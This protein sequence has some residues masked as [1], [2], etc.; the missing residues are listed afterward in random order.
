MSNTID[1]RIVQMK[2]NNSQFEQG[3]S[4][5]MNT[6]DKLKKSLDF[7]DTEKALNNLNK[8]TSENTLGELGNSASIVEAKLSALNV[9]A[10]TVVSN[11]TTSVINA[12][13]KISSSLYDLGV[14]GGLNRALNIEQAKFQLEGLGITW[15]SIS[16][17][18]SYAVNETAYSL[19][20]AAK[21]ASTL[22]ATGIQVGNIAR[23]IET[24]DS[25]G[26][27]TTSTIDSMAESLR[28]ISG[29]ASQTGASY[30]NVSQ[31]FSTIAGNGRIMGMQ[32]TQLASYG[33]NVAADMANAFG[34]TE[35]E[36]RDQVSEGLIS[37]E[38]F[39][40]VMFDKYADHAVKANETLSG[41]ASNIRS[42]FAKI[43]AE[44][45]QPIV[46]NNGPLV[47][48]LNNFKS[49][50]DE[51]KVAMIPMMEWLSDDAIKVINKI[52]TGLKNLDFSKLNLEKGTAAFTNFHKAAAA[53]Q[54]I[55][56]ALA[57]WIK[58]AWNGIVSVFQ[59]G[60]LQ[61]IFDNLTSTITNFFSKLTLGEKGA[62]N[63]QRI[64]RGLTSVFD[65]FLKLLNSIGIGFLKFEGITVEAGSGLLDILA[66][67]GDWLYQL[68][69][70]IPDVSS[71]FTTL[72]NVLSDITSKAN[73][74]E[75]ILS[76]VAGTIKLI[77]QAFQAVIPVLSKAFSF[78]GGIIHQLWDAIT[79]S[80]DLTKII[81]MGLFGVILYQLKKIGI[82]INKI[83][84]AITAKGSFLGLKDLA[85][86]VSLLLDQVHDS[87]FAWEESLKANFFLKIASAI[88]ILAVA[89]TVISNIDVDKLVKAL[90]A[91]SLLMNKLMTNFATFSNLSLGKGVW[92]L[93]AV[94]IGFTASIL[95][96]A[97]AVKKLSSIDLVGLAKGIAG[98]LILI[99]S[100]TNALDS[101]VISK[102]TKI[103]KCS[104]LLLSLA[105]SIRVLVSSV[106]ALSKLSI[107]ELVKGLASVGVLLQSIISAANKITV[108]KLAGIGF[109]LME[110]AVAIRVLASSAKVFASM[111]WEGLA[112]ADASILVL[113][114]ALDTFANGV[115]GTK[116]LGVGAS[117]TLLGNAMLKFAASSK[118]FAS[119]SWEELARAGLAFVGVLTAV[120][121]G[122]K[123]ATT[124]DNPGMIA[125]YAG[126]LTAIGLAMIEFGAY[127]KIISSI[128]WDG[129]AKAVLSFISVIGIIAGLG[130]VLANLNKTN[131]TMN[132]DL[133]KFA[134]IMAVFGIVLNIMSPAI[135][136]L[137]TM[138]LS[139]AIVAMGS[140]ITIIAAIEVACYA[141]QAV[142]WSG[143]A[144]ASVGLLAFGV[145]LGIVAGIIATVTGLTDCTGAIKVMEAVGKL[146]VEMA[147]ALDLLT[148]AG[149]FAAFALTGLGVMIAAIASLTTLVWAIGALSD[150]GTVRKFERGVEIM[151]LVGK[152]IGEFFGNIVSGFIDGATN[153][154]EETADRL[155]YFI[156]AV[157]DMMD[158]VE[159]IDSECLTSCKNIV[160]A[161]KEFGTIDYAKLPSTDATYAVRSQLLA[162]ADLFIA[163]SNKF[164]G[165]VPAAADIKKIFADTAS[166]SE[167]LDSMITTLNG[168]TWN[169]QSV[170]DEAGLNILQNKIIS[171]IGFM[172]AFYKAI[173]NDPDFKLYVAKTMFANTNEALAGLSS[174][175]KTMSGIVWDLDYLP[176]NEDIVALQAKM[177]SLVGLM[178]SYYNALHE[179]DMLLS[180]AG[181]MFENSNLALTGL[182]SCVKTAGT[183]VWDASSLPDA[184]QT[185]E[186]QTKL[187]NLALLMLAYYQVYKDNNVVNFENAKTLFA[188]AAEATEALLTSVQN[189]GFANLNLKRLPD[190]SEFDEFGE[191]LNGIADLIIG[192]YHTYTQDYKI[193]QFDRMI[194]VFDGSTDAVRAFK[195]H[196]WSINGVTWSAL[197]FPTDEKVENLKRGLTSI[198]GLIIEY[199]RVYKRDYH[200]T[201]FKNMISLFND[202]TA[203]IN[204]F[205]N[206]VWE[207][208][209]I[210]WAALTV[211]KDSEVNNLLSRLKGVAG[212]IVEYYR[213]YK[214]DYHI[215]NFD[216]MITLFRDT[217]NAID[218]FKDHLWAMNSNVWYSI[219]IPTESESS[220]LSNK[221]NAIAA[222]LLSYYQVY[223]DSHITDL[224]NLKKLFSDSSEAFYSLS[225]SVK[226][227]GDISNNMYYLPD[228]VTPYSDK[229][230]SM[231]NMLIGF[232]KIFSENGFA[233]FAAAK[234]LF[235]NVA[236]STDSFEAMTLSLGNACSNLYDF[237]SASDISNLGEA[238]KVGTDLL[239]GIYKKFTDAGISDFYPAV[240]LFSSS[241]QACTQFSKLVN[242][243]VEFN[244]AANGLPD[245]QSI[246][247]WWAAIR[248]FV[249]HL[250]S[251]YQE[252]MADGT[253]DATAMSYTFESFNSVTSSVFELANAIR[254]ND[255]TPLDSATDFIASLKQFMT[256][257]AAIG[258][259]TDSESIISVLDLMTQIKTSIESTRPEIES[260]SLELG[261]SI[262]TSM[263]NALATA[264][265]IGALLTIKIGTG[266]MTGAS[267]VK[268]QA[269]NVINQAV[270]AAKVSALS[271][272]GIG[273]NFCTGIALGIASNRSMVINQAVQTAVAAYQA[274]CAA[275]QIQSPSRK[276]IEV[277]KFFDLG[278]ANGIE[279]YSKSIEDNATNVSTTAL[280]VVK[281]AIDNATDFMKV[282]DDYTPT[283]RPILDLSSVQ[284]GSRELADM[285]NGRS[286]SA[287]IT[288][289]VSDRLNK[290]AAYASEI[291]NTV[292]D[293]SNS[294]VQNYTFN[295]TNNSPK[296]L[297]RYQIYRQTRN[298]I[299]MMKGVMS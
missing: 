1:E 29:V 159:G 74:L 17:D 96:L 217:T 75:I 66:K 57:S 147:V 138:Q 81:K 99:K 261:S 290:N 242:G 11:I 13:S 288:G 31:I 186:I 233:N 12:V 238:L 212:L 298:Q 196:I 289:N 80:G 22:A 114:T 240:D 171:L 105:V 65:I 27:K 294:V 155:T 124:L 269:I 126:S 276:M 82:Q 204:A 28:A 47:T 228:D 241:E 83:I 265:T 279:N 161:I 55:L 48:L 201:N 131:K 127:A 248:V 14:T 67:I 58:P 50:V 229:L 41:I 287:T 157:A 116:I 231:A 15:D 117:M 236:D 121:L 134:G 232:Y 256:D 163:Y 20:A 26:I 146:A 37:Y 106:A 130:V 249:R 69:Q 93:P 247:M 191:K 255:L 156:D 59:N 56:T 213:T 107:E 205:K 2:F 199:Y 197:T 100:L 132:A 63:I 206:H 200:I 162:I 77:A 245:M 158:T 32:L 123:A 211:P 253:F 190:V 258:T 226:A 283:I 285:F 152:A 70:S 71:G 140:I 72:G 278:F 215:T 30:E 51:I 210:T 172:T 192:Y 135:L 220:T 292:R 108:E 115:S 49:K 154:L 160:K 297:D 176:E 35:A 143:I 45:F 262:I 79:D 16:G 84:S 153:T 40:D 254:S 224:S 3:A 90:A 270:T 46:E 95:I 257:L 165:E 184:D 4:Q 281:D 73:P 274:A 218:I 89:L 23:E 19:D 150:G 8:A 85:G 173:A 230:N 264:N 277:G 272:V 296:A 24:V 109:G 208:N 76:A 64:F 111:S 144:K 33:L 139:E 98:T 243:I 137:S 94:L 122:I 166:A 221:I 112:K 103:A 246:Q 104:T 235:A 42:A 180:H 194:T 250:I 234:K 97:S 260:A 167:S 68:D 54:T 88:G 5:T 142:K 237:P 53:V 149:G 10:M 128:S 168:V 43:G 175:L 291:A 189:M 113:L 34:I 39:V 25:A 259:D 125:L 182:V 223:K 141:M 174:C 299:A 164:Q 275:L 266:I 110:I 252:I 92:G 286:V 282:D 44:F 133:L 280:D 102:K 193:W 239:I 284:N 119:L 188:D 6:V 207:V 273:T 177:T 7:G 244:D 183:I 91:V 263:Q 268:T 225:D 169:L 60:R 86:K 170:P 198:A 293:K 267:L 222:L 187:E 181:T 271:A 52:S 195:S 295:Q 136:M 216:N 202:T 129:L 101:F 38:Q 145:V 251:I 18:L 9:V 185:K 78:V 36:L 61:E 151:S 209:G 214:R 87:L 118:I 179:S 62:N 148:I 120:G 21:A 203:A 178:E 219:S 227:M